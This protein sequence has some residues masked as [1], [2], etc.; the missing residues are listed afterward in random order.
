MEKKAL[1]GLQEDVAHVKGVFLVAAENAV[2]WEDAIP[3]DNDAFTMVEE[4]R[5][6]FYDLTIR[7][8]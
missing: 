5:T 7:C 1:Y 8:C 3:D 6:Y 4:T 2:H